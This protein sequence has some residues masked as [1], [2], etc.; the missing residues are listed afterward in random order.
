MDDP[1]FNIEEEKAA[2]RRAQKINEMKRL[3]R[4]Q[5]QRR[6]RLRATVPFMA[7]AL[8]VCILVFAGIKIFHKPI[9]HTDNFSV[10]E[11]TADTLQKESPEAQPADTNAGGN[12]N[13]DGNINRLPNENHPET[14]ETSAGITPLKAE[15]EQSA[16]TPENTVIY[17]ASETKSTRQIS[18]EIASS[19]GILIDLGSNTILAEKAAH[20]RINPASMTKILTVLVAAEHIK[21]LDDTFTMNL[22]IT[23]YCYVNDCSNAGFANGETITIKDLFYGAILPSGGEAALGLAV[24]TSGSQEA[25]VR[26]M[27][28]KLKE[29]G[30]SETAHFTNCIG[31]YDENHYCTIYDMAIIMKA[32]I[33]NDFCR[34]VLSTHTYTTSKTPE[35]PEGIIISNWFLRRIEDKETGGEV[36]CAKTGYVVQSGSCAASYAVD[37]AGNYYICV[38]ADAH[39]PWRCIYDHVELYQQFLL[40]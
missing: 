26:L 10:A 22:K 34:E 20:T 37:N 9:G 18:D 40:P 31:L 14:Q 36:L 16:D 28:K 5:E 35:H 32:A 7:G 8:C 2:L 24:Y 29:L 15:N 1:F 12:K 30:L 4:I 6:R 27:N 23:D 17:T 39:S 11:N 19:N 33:E 13:T 21:N 38:T 25:F 3:K